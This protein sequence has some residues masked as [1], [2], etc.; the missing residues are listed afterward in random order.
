MQLP[1][2]FQP[3]EPAFLALLVLVPV[4]VMT[5]YRALGALSTT[6]RT[7]ALTLRAAAITLIVCA[8][9]DFQS[10]RRTDD[11][12]TAF[13]LDTSRSVP[14][15][16]QQAGLDYVRDATATMRPDHDRVALVTC[17]GDGRIEQ[18][19]YSALRVMQLAAAPQLDQTNLAAGLRL[20]R[21]VLPVDTARRIVL[22]S[23]GNANAGDTQAELQRLAAEGVPV[24]VLPLVYNHRDEVTFER[25]MAPPKARAGDRVE[26]SLVIR[27]TKPT[28]GR[29]L[30]YHNGQPID[31]DPDSPGLD[32]PV[33]LD[34]GL[35]RL[36]Q[37]V[38]LPDSGV[39]RFRAVFTPDAPDADTIFANN[40]AESFTIV[41]G[42]DRVLILHEGGGSGGGKA[43]ASAEALAGA[44]AEHDIDCTV[45]DVDSVALDPAELMAYS[46]VILS[47]VSA[48][49]LGE[50]QQETLA[51]YV[52][53]L[54]GGLITVGGDNAFGV[55]GY[56]RAPLEEVLPV[57]TDR[58]KLQLLSLSMVIVI[59]RSGS[60]MGEKIER[61][62]QAAGG[63]IGLLGGLDRIGVLAFAGDTQWVVPLMPCEN[64]AGIQRRL[65]HI[66]SGGGT[67]MYPA[68]VEAAR[69]LRGA[70]TNVRHIILLTDG[71]SIPGDFDG[72]ARQLAA[73]NITVSAI[74]IG[75]D[76]D[77]A[78][79]TRIA[80]I[81]GGRM[82]AT[83]DAA[84]L[85][86][87][88]VRETVLAGR[89]GTYQRQFVPA[90]RG[91]LQSPIV[92]G[93]AAT[94]LPP[95][96]G[97]DV[98][99][100][101]PLATVPLL[102]A[103]DEGVD[104]ILAHWQVG[105]GRSVAFT[106]GMWPRWGRDWTPWS[107]FSKFWSQAA[108]WTARSPD[109]TD[110]DVRVAR[111]GDRARVTLEAY[112]AI[113]LVRGGLRITGAVVGPDHQPRPLD[114]KPVGLGRYEGEFPTGQAGSYIVRAAYAWHA[115]GANRTGSVQT[116]VTV[117][118]AAE[119]RD[120]QSNEQA[121]AEMARAT[122][123]RVLYP[124]TPQ[125]VYEPWSRRTVEITKPVWELLVRLA[126]VCFLADVAVRRIAVEPADVVAFSRRFIAGLVHGAPEAAAT[127]ATLRRTRRRLRSEAAER[128]AAELAGS[129]ASPPG[130][131][132]AGSNVAGE[133]GPGPRPAEATDLPFTTLD[134]P[135]PSAPPV[136]PPRPDTP[137]SATAEPADAGDARA[138]LLRAKRRARQELDGPGEDQHG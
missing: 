36:M 4:L 7:V 75:A 113:G 26:L 45:A 97:Y 89:S 13:V 90:L 38:Q 121:L 59:D 125:A 80:K 50:N 74:G 127:T 105:L 118:Y 67:D 44:L 12:T 110:F 30:V 70:D 19:A 58:K 117:P 42:S 47:N 107:G 16:L 46:L 99:S 32:V 55:G 66:G 138:R 126:L 9:A 24:D 128:R 135:A 65:T 82:Y 104:P 3:H 83:S 57:V 33:T 98:T 78:L 21:A 40:Q 122:G 68:L 31:L 11:L 61:A 29:I 132:V 18:P 25:L 88:F 35:N 73:D 95:L 92:S 109:A 129:Q 41:G 17:A 51:A 53:D 43:R 72:I 115:D 69:A 34:A 108:R 49:A 28:S 133:R 54:G 96:Y 14:E 93:I 39:H 5:S 71:Q 102:R 85:P 86:Q 22:I 81:T 23:D 79:L 10:V 62:K 94:D 48:I 15:A 60:M 106:S 120:R 137:T 134:P 91:G 124:E 100:A 37:A 136:K 119:Y 27:A 101:R 8:L 6:R 2:W 87:I 52:R 76:T 20:A 84:P 63:A 114:L 56:Y 123:G 77:T 1:I 116:S 130:S 111:D 64:K 112:D 131:S 103:T